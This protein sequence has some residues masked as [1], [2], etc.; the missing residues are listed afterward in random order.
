MTLFASFPSYT[1]FEPK[2]PVVCVTPGDCS[3]IHRFY[4]TSP[5]SPSGIYIGLTRFYFEDRLPAPGDAAQVI[6][7]NLKTGKTVY[8]TDTL[9]WDTQ[10][11]AHVQWG[12]D[13]S[14]LFFNRMN[15]TDWHPYGCRVDI[16]TGTETRLE[17]TVYTV[18]PDGTKISSPDLRKISNV[19]AGYSIITPPE[20]RPKN[21]G[22]PADDGL[23]ITDA[24]TGKSKLVLSFKQIVDALPGAFAGLDME[25]GAFYGFHSKWNA[26]GSRIMFII[27]W[28]PDGARHNVSNNYLITCK[29]DGSEVTM[30]V[31]AARWRGGHHPTWCPDGEHIIMNLV[32]NRGGKFFR[33]QLFFQRV[34]RKL[35][36]RYFPKSGRLAFAYIHYSGEMKFLADGCDGSGHPTLNPEETHIL[37]DSYPNERVSFAD[38]TVPLRWVD[39]KTAHEVC[40]VRIGATPAYSGPH[41]EWRVDPHPTWTQDGRYIVFN[42]YWDGHRRVFVAEIEHV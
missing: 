7:I 36:I 10:V 3:A 26:Q 29:P 13:D 39:I 12:A 28:K 33:L 35:K 23:F 15:K 2:I 24:Q 25:N 30:A 8:E 1:D 18:S 20:T 9:A 4:D 22:V 37:S 6:V 41:L 42:G 19:Q 21:K 40:L 5:I 17:G 27:R 32:K 31:D 11:G 14:A 38:G 34:A 16:H